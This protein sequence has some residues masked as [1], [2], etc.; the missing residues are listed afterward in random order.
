[1]NAA[2]CT[3]ADVPLTTLGPKT[4]EEPT[5]ELPTPAGWEHSAS[6]MG[7]PMIRGIVV[8]KGLRANDFTPNAV[9]TLED[10]TG[11][12]A[13]AQQGIEAEV[14][15]AQQAGIAVTSRTPGTVCGHPSATITYTLKGHSV[16]ALVVAAAD[17]QKVWA[18]TLTVQTAEPDNPAYIADKQ[19]IIN[20]FQFVVPSHGTTQ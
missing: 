15:G 1:M 10:L 7:S 4:A 3:T 18:A 5:L 16:T 12:V 6:T 11:K 8:N 13:D 14:V 9:V 19:K 2:R 17:G 20:N